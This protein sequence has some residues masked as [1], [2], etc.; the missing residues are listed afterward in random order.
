MLLTED[1][2]RAFD[3]PSR[4]HVDAVRSVSLRVGRGEIY[5]LLGPNGAG[6]T[7]TLRMLATLLRPDRGRIEI[8]GVDARKQPVQARSRLAYV[9]A[10]AGLPERLTAAETVTLFGDIQGVAEAGRRARELLDRLGASRYADTNCSAL[11]TGMKRRVVLARALVHD[12]PL[13]LLDEPTDGLDVGGRREVLGLVRG[14]AAEGRAVVVSS[15]IMGEVETL[16][17]RVGV[18]AGG[19]IVA[20]GSVADLLATTGT[21]E[22]GDAFM[23]LTTESAA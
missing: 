18:M 10:E 23:A 4:G 16:C 17:P 9:P 14:L 3:D 19:R 2:A 20:E 11:S 7:T 12:P 22:L 6:K 15:H 8:D 21:H 13:L 5:G 1:L